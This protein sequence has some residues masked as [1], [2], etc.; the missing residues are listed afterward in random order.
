MCCCAA[1]AGCSRRARSSPGL[2]VVLSWSAASLSGYFTAGT[3][4][5][6]SRLYRGNRTA[7]LRNSP[8]WWVSHR[9]PT[10]PPLY[11]FASTAEHTRP[12]TV[13]QEAALTAAIRSHAPR[14]LTNA[15]LLPYGA[16]T[17]STWEVAVPPALDWLAGFLPQALAPA[18]TVPPSPGPEPK[19][20]SLSVGGEGGSRSLPSSR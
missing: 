9:A 8:L 10:A 15:V 14:L 4:P 20:S 19:Q 18:I 5:G 7:L 11:L 2:G 6:T 17:W 1:A 16:H 13:R 3:G 12:N